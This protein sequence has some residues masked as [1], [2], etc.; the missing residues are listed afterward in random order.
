MHDLVKKIYFLLGKV[1]LK[2]GLLWQSNDHSISLLVLGSRRRQGIL[3]TKEW[4]AIILTYLH[5][6]G[7][8]GRTLTAR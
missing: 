1:H 4:S 2:V 3:S 5:I 7:T 8:V 6:V